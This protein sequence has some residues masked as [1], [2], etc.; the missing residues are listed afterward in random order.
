MAKTVMVTGG[1]QGIGEAISK[2]L[3]KDGFTVVIADLN[4]QKAEAVAET[5]KS[6]G[7]QALAVQTD[8]SD[9]ASFFSAVRTAAERLGR[10]DVLVNNA[11]IAPGTP[12][13]TVTAEDFD[14]IFRINVASIVWGTQA[15]LEQFEKKERQGTEIIGKIINASSQ[16]GVVGNAGAFLYS[17]SKFAVR[18]LTQVAAK[19]LAAKGIT[20]N[21]YAPGTVKTPMLLSAVNDIAQANNQDEEWALQQF[22]QN[23]TLGRLS[24]PEDVAAGVA[25]LAGSDSDYMTGQTLEIDGG[26][27]FH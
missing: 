7:G 9:R 11:G 14:Q 15:A 22:S 5:I 6:L 20:V 25:F 19:D 13:E 26:M 16:G 24:E 1:A 2:R 4:L 21:A 18:G 8:V 12:I 3:A 27:Q 10:F 17:G 23:I